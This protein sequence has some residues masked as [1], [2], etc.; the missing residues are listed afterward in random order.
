MRAIPLLLGYLLSFGAIANATASSMTADGGM[1][2]AGSA[3]TDHNSDHG[4]SHGSSSASGDALN[5]PHSGASTP[6]GNSRSASG[7]STTDDTPAHFGG[8]DAS[9]GGVSHG[10]GL[11]W[12]SLLPGSIQ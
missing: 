2:A 3:S 1:G 7:A 8:D 10:S 9:P 5:I 6:S 12:Q 11:G 4:A